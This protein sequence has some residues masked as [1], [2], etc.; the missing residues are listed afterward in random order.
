VHFAG[1]KVGE[2][3]GVF[4]PKKNLIASMCLNV[5]MWFCCNA[6]EILVNNAA[7]EELEEDEGEDDDEDQAAALQPSG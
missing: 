3:K 5:R 4:R 7:V 2:K 6:D 1:K